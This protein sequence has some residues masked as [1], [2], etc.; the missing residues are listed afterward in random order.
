MPARKRAET[1]DDYDMKERPSRVNRRKEYTRYDNERPRNARPMHRPKSPRHEE[2]PAPKPAPMASHKKRPE[3]E[4]R[5]GTGRRAQEP[6]RPTT[7]E[8]YYYD[9]EEEPEEAPPKRNRRPTQKA[10]EKVKSTSKQSPQ[11]KERVPEEYERP[12]EPV[13]YGKGSTSTQRNPKANASENEV[14]KVSPAY[15]EIPTTEINLRATSNEK[16]PKTVKAVKIVN[17]S[18][19]DEI[20]ENGDAYAHT[21]A[22]TRM[23]STQMKPISETPPPPPPKYSSV[24]SLKALNP[25]HRQA[26]YTAEPSRKDK[27]PFDLD[28]RPVNKTVTPVRHFVASSP[29]KPSHYAPPSPPVSNY[30]DDSPPYRGEEKPYKLPEPVQ[31]PAI[32]TEYYKPLQY[33]PQNVSLYSGV[34]Y[35]PYS[36]SVPNEPK[37]NVRPVKEEHLVPETL[38]AITNNNYFSTGF[39]SEPKPF[40]NDNSKSTLANTQQ[41]YRQEHRLYGNGDRLYTTNSISFPP[42][43]PS[44]YDI[45]A[46]GPSAPGE[47]PTAPEKKYSEPPTYTASADYDVT[48]NDALQPSTLHPVRRYPSTSFY[49]HNQQQRSIAP[50]RVPS[51]YAFNESAFN[52]LSRSQT[53]YK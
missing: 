2:E 23:S 33:A 10:N 22:E 16:H 48:Y 53:R 25:H 50:S 13:K 9:E 1:Y 32:H 3:S 44:N 8:D 35:R 14:P 41:N 28:N 39:I 51:G 38:N 40:T 34:N 47:E 7:E 43:P 21:E 52:S 11:S 26:E 24:V 42:H 27:K 29:R 19:K 15:N 4:Y 46:P 12:A 31:K 20:D 36:V 37:H 18:L 5:M 49:S 45:T 30:R 6:K 17:N